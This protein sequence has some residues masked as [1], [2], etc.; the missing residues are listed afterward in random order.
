MKSLEKQPSRLKRKINLPL[1]KSE[2]NRWLIISKV[3]KGNL[4]L[5][6]LSE[7]EDT[8][9]L[10]NLLRQPKGQIY[11]C[12][13]AG[14]VFRF[15]TAYL[16]ITPGEHLI[17][18][19]DRLKERPI[20]P[21]VKALQAMGADIQ[22]MEKKGFAP[23][24]IKGKPLRGGT[25]TLDNSLSSQFVSALMLISPAIPEPLTIKICQ[26]G[27]SAPY[28]YMTANILKKVG[29]KVSIT[30]STISLEP[31]TQVD[32]NRILDVFPEKDWSSASYCYGLAY[33]SETAEFYFP[34]LAI[35]S[36]QGDAQIGEYFAPLGVQTIDTGAGVRIVKKTERVRVPMVKINA[37]GTPD[38]A[39][40]LI[41]ALSAAKQPFHIS[42]LSTLKYKE[43]DRLKALQIELYKIGVELEV[44]V[45]YC[46]YHGN[47]KLHLPTDSF[48]VYDDH[49]MAMALSQISALCP[50][51]IN[52]PEV[53]KKSFPGFWEEVF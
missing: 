46:A 11:D 19:S 37:A 40:G 5:R 7:A 47:G 10:Y 50:I 42:G 41:V 14:T 12:G 51:N 18:G 35:K 28:I 24:K 25:L 45:D 1:S 9:L 2:C 38:L 23:L 30:G 27:I 43:T 52:H 15:M 4:R 22:Y 44:G 17:T 3:F 48:E 53:V 32:A 39:Q 6:G 16:A 13:P 31:P 8:R 49:R 34:G 36:H 29:V 26:L 20:E 21:L 33:L